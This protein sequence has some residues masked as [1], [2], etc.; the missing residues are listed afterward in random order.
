MGEFI[1]SVQS[2]SF[3]HDSASNPVFSGISFG[4]GMGWHGLVGANGSGKTTLAR[5]IAGLLPPKSGRIHR[6]GS[7]LYLE[8]IPEDVPPQLMELLCT[9]DKAIQAHL[10]RL[11]IGHDWPWRWETLSGGEKKRA[12][13]ALALAS[14]PDILILDEPGN[15]LDESARNILIHGLSRWQGIGILISHDRALLDALTSSTL[16]MERGGLTRY[17]CSVSTALDQREH[18]RHHAADQAEQIRSTISRLSVSHGEKKQKVDGSQKRMSR[19]GLAPKDHDGREKANRARLT[20]KDRPDAAAMMRLASR[21]NQLEEELATL[22]EHGSR[23]EGV[24]VWGQPSDKPFW[25]RRPAGPLPLGDGRTLNLPP[26]DIARTSRIMLTGENGSGKT[27]LLTAIMQEI[28][29]VQDVYFMPQEIDTPSAL[30][31]LD[32][33]AGMTDF[34]EGQVWSFVARLGT[35]PKPLRW[36]RSTAGEHPE[37]IACSPGELRKILL[38]MAFT[39][40]ASL[41]VLDEPTN[42]MDLLSVRCLSAAMK[43]Y[44]GA[45]LAVSHDRAFLGEICTVEW[46]I[47]NQAGNL[48]IM[49][50]FFPEDSRASD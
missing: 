9:P 29:P 26:L 23:K 13:I 20:G 39:Q 33:L 11:A 44:S 8:Q 37:S 31:A 27:T 5:C 42:H 2:L 18:N 16:I 34:E 38:A 49:V 48:E 28:G 46:Q 14:E 1:L 17:A 22:P 47:D 35:D 43:D 50:P 25:I 24:S 45:I 40:K 6:P 30:S 4:L 21:I 3:Q 12:Q 7:I 36:M 19:R 32:R 41:I 15:H 10:S